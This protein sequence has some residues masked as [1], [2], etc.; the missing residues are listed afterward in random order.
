MVVDGVVEV[1]EVAHSLNDMSEALAQRSTA[2]E[3]AVGELRESNAHLRQARAG[4]A[5]AERLAAVGSLAAGVA[6]EVG[7][8]M[9]A[10]LAFL[11]LAERDS[12]ITDEGRSH[13]HRAAEQGARVR[14]ILRQLLD[15]SRPPQ[16]RAAPVDLAR[17]A[18][19]VQTLIGAQPS[20]SEIE[21]KVQTERGL[22]PVRSD[23]SMLSQ[24]L[25]NLVVNS[26]DAIKGS[27]GRDRR[28]QLTLRPAH[29]ETRSAD[30]ESAS[31]DRLVFD[32][33]ACVVEDSGPGI[34]DEVRDRIFDPFFTT[35]P[36]GEGTGLGLANA[37]KLVEEIGGV[38]E[39]LRGSELGGAAFELR[40]PT[41]GP[42]DAAG[43]RG[44]RAVRL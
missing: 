14:E 22:L 20:Y 15:F 9:G 8:P 23:E 10:L 29:L 5:R 28:I 1:Q 2:L 42:N 25:L 27:G 6:H 13:L 16:A 19:Q 12:E 38:I 37:L 43:S 40:L 31:L 26:A 4:L 11:S 33:M 39:C 24:I 34:D 17:V 32:A 21:F 30:E 44:V 35:K 36:P 7:N 18:A 41:A 3:K